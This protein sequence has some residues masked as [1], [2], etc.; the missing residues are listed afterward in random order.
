MAESWLTKALGLHVKENAKPKVEVEVVVNR[1]RNGCYSVQ[2]FYGDEL[3]RWTPVNLKKG[4][5]VVFI[6]GL[7]E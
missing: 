6:H 3:L 5:S 7:P 1:D 2:V 4:E